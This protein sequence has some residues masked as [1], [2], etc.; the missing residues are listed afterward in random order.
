MLHKFHR[1]VVIVGVQ[2][3]VMWSHELRLLHQPIANIN[4]SAV[5][6]LI[7]VPAVNLVRQHN[8]QNCATYTEDLDAVL[9]GFC[10]HVL[11]EC[12]STA[13]VLDHRFVYCDVFASGPYLS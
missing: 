5:C 11:Y 7:L 9:D 6:L 13:T 2:C 12:H 10:R 3:S 8:P 4:C 1:R